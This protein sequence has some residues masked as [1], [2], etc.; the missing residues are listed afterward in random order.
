MA[1]P[2]ISASDIGRKCS[3]LSK[4]TSDV[5]SW[6]GTILGCVGVDIA[7][8]FTDIV[9]YNAAV[10]HADASVPED[11]TLLN[12]FLVQV[13]P[14]VGSG[15]F[16]RYA[17]AQEWLSD[18]SFQFV[19]PGTIIRLDILD[20]SDRDPLDLLTILRAQGYNPRIT[21]IVTPD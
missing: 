6:R 7:R 12:F 8:M 11:V 20:P 15:E 17:F 5:T 3:F 4:S 10:R 18:N 21:E 19:N 16:P 1:N 9:S 13:E 14:G 2:I